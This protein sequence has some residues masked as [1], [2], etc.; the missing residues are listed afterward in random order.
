MVVICLHSSFL[1]SPSLLSPCLDRTAQHALLE[2]IKPLGPLGSTSST[3]IRVFVTVFSSW[4]SIGCF[5]FFIF[6]VHWIFMCDPMPLASS[7]HI[8]GL[9][10]WNHTWNE[11]S[12]VKNSGCW[13]EL[14]FSAAERKLYG[15]IIFTILSWFKKKSLW[16]LLTPTKWVLTGINSFSKELEP[17]RPQHLFCLWQGGRKHSSK[18]ELFSP[19]RFESD[20]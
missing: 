11:N 7:P 13:M 14:N 15:L 10:G 1:P 16:R 2:D 19:L 5:F 3:G 20:F 17:S 6:Q 4:G 18:W 8:N 9:K 12:R